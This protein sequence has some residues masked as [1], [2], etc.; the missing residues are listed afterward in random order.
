MDAESWARARAIFD[1][2]VDLPASDWETQL[3]ALGIVDAA[4]RGEILSLLRADRAEVIATEVDAQAP[5]VLAQFAEADR[6][7]QHARL[8]GQTVGAF[9]LIDEIGRGG[10]GTV[11]LAQRVDGEF[12][13]QVAIKLIRA[14]WDAGEVDARFRAERQI[15][16]GLTHPNIARLIDG[17]VTVDGRPWLALEYV[18]GVDL[19]A[20]CERGQLDLRARL[21]LFLTVCAA[22]SHAHSHLIVHRD[23]KP[24]NLLVTA[25]GE[26]KLLD[27]GIAKLIDG[28]A[29]H[30][31]QT[32]V[33]TP[34][35]AAPE[36]VRGEAV[37]TA[38]DVHALGLLLYE[39]LTGKRP[40]KVSHSTPAAY[41]RAILDQEPTRPSLAWTREPDDADAG[42]AQ[43]LELSARRLAR[44]LR[45]D[46]DAIVL[47]ALRKDPAD[48]YPSVAEFALD[49]DNHLQRRPVAARRGGWRYRATRFLRR[50]ALAAALASFAFLALAS[51]LAAAVWQANEARAQRDLAR[52]ESAKATQTRQFLLDIFRSADP[53]LTQGRKV[54]AEELLRRG[55]ERIA[56]QQLQDPGVHFDLLMAMGEAWLGIGAGSEA[57][58]LFEQALHVQ[59]TGLAGDL[60]K[61]VRAL[62]L[63]ARSRGRTDDTAGATR[64]L[65]EAVRLLPPAAA[66]SELAADLAVSRGIN[67]MT[68]GDITG[69]IDDMARGVALFTRLRGPADDQTA[70][71]AITLSW[72]YDDQDRHREARA[73][74][75][76]IVA[77]LHASSDANP[78]RLADALDA[79]ANTF[80]ASSEAAAAASMRKEALEITRRVYGDTHGFVEIRLNNLSFSLLRAHDY[81]GANAAMKQALV[82]RSAIEPAGSRRIGTSLNNLASTEFAL[83]NWAEAE[84]LWTQALVI[85]R[86]GTDITDVAF[87]LSGSAAAAREQGKLSD[88]RIRIDEAL[89]ILRAHPSPKPTHLARTLIERTEV[90]LAFNRIDCAGAEEAMALMQAHTN[91]DDPQRRYAEVVAAGCAWRADA[92]AQ[93]RQRV[94]AAQ[95]ALRA[96]FP[97]DSARVRQAQRYALAP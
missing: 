78:V 65:E 46:L 39:L 63:L 45:G 72:A 11:W 2:L 61:R 57:L 89:E 87:S 83:G 90:D 81:A 54:S 97:A 37:T 79:L 35:Y 80:N 70:S 58:S 40:Y 69:S 9:R 24:S 15:L 44:E 21:R 85:R 3:D 23:L 5:Q 53:A 31:S 22:V 76:P 62:T 94:H 12:E 67:R 77:A 55:T 8:V 74:L 19:R 36:Q 1:Q 71:A 84:R 41:E 7:A 16:A 56:Q 18:D 86:K 49:I 52:S 59:E 51:G 95:A 13:Q 48:R 92:S 42:A 66:E 17:G 20:F 34:E 14:G 27:F 25:A 96:E 60:L 29:T 88:A 73:L 43:P 64:L 82:L 93:N 68:L 6:N 32:R 10:M 4:L 47:K 38:V 75:E 26:V 28:N 91:S 50:H 30:A 33:F